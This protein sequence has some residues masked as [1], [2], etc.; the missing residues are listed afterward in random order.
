MLLIPL[1]IEQFLLAQR[2]AQKRAIRSQI[3]E[4]PTHFLAS[5]ER[6]FALMKIR[7][8][9]SHSFASGLFA[10]VLLGHGNT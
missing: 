4:Q 6:A 10:G 2:L 5:R 7:E 3:T 8:V 1:T 9:H